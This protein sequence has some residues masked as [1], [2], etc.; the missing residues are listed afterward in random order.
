MADQF[1]AERQIRKS[2][3]KEPS[4]S[5]IHPSGVNHDVNGQLENS[6]KPNTGV[7]PTPKSDPPISDP[8]LVN[9]V[10]QT[11]DPHVE[12]HLKHALVN[13]HSQL[14]E[15]APDFHGNGPVHGPVHQSG[16]IQHDVKPAVLNAVASSTIIIPA[17][18]PSCPT[19]SGF[20]MTIWSARIKSPNFFDLSTSAGSL[21][22]ACI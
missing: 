13:R 20:L 6:G 2:R 15:V 3:T 19:A 22:R 1:D 4:S 10:I 18:S 17:R 14:P 21:R 7:S 12:L 5:H 16:G 11:S 8:S 9:H